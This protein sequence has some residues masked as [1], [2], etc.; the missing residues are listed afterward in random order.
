MELRGLRPAQTAL[1]ERSRSFGAGERCLPLAETLRKIRQ[2]DRLAIGYHQSA[3]VHHEKKSVYEPTVNYWK[4]KYS[5]IRIELAEGRQRRPAHDKCLTSF[6]HHPHTIFGPSCSVTPVSS[7]YI[8]NY[9]KQRHVNGDR[10]RTHC[11]AEQSDGITVF[12]ISPMESLMLHRCRTGAI[13]LQSV[14][15]TTTYTVAMTAIHPSSS[16]VPIS[17]QHDVIVVHRSGEIRNTLNTFTCKP[18]LT[19][20]QQSLPNGIWRSTLKKKSPGRNSIA[21][22]LSEATLLFNEKASAYN[23]IKVSHIMNMYSSGN[24]L[25]VRLLLRKQSSTTV[26]CESTMDE[27]IQLTG[28]DGSGSD[29]GGDGSEIKVLVLVITLS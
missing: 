4:L 8:C 1:D 21:L 12:R 26:E 17:L 13:S 9:N 14:A 7:L 2:N 24:K 16:F 19:R 11:S 23:Y 27:I 22:R 6:H 20:T 5:L 18:K 29:D 3:E 28:D 25:I 15:Q 10:R